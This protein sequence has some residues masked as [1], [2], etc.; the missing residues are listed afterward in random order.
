MKFMEWSSKFELGIPDMDKQ[1]QRWLEILNNFYE[2]MDNDQIS[3]NVKILIDEVLDY[4]NYHFK[5]EE[6]F[7]T[8]IHYPNI[9]DQ[10]QMHSDIIDMIKGYRDKAEQGKLIISM[11]LTTELKRW[12]KEHILI[13]DMKYSQFFLNQ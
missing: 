12:F 7:L 3:E 5:E 9:E 1:H 11:T 10:K 2:K 4:T 13:E 6:R 8:S